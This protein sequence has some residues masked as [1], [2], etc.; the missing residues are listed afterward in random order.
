MNESNMVKKKSDKEIR[1]GDSLIIENSVSRHPQKEN[2]AEGDSLV[3]VVSDAPASSVLTSSG[4]ADS[5]S[6]FCRCL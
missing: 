1:G 5:S 6:V 2:A 4:D 3:S